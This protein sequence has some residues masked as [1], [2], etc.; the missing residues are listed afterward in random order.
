MAFGWFKYST[1]TAPN[2]TINPVSYSDFLS[3][4]GFVTGG[5]KV[6]YIYASHVIAGGIVR[7]VITA[8]LQ[9]EIAT[10]VAGSTSSPNV[11]VAST[12]P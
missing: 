8:S 11:Y 1:P 5:N 9:T 4:P 6:N 3:I 7:P 12:L 10:A 2:P